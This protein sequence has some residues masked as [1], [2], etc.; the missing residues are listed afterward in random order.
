MTKSKYTP[1]PWK[2]GKS[3]G[4]YPINCDQSGGPGIMSALTKSGVL[5][6]ARANETLA[7]AAPELLEALE[8]MVNMTVATMNQRDFAYSLSTAAFD[9]ARTA[10]A[11]AKGINPDGR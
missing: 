8:A 11:K 2:R 1:G 5:P 6:N 4:L 7:A 9:I 10:I 3:G